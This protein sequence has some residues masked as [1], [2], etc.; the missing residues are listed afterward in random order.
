MDLCENLKTNDSN[1]F[2]AFAKWVRD[3]YR[4]AEHCLNVSFFARVAETSLTEWHEVAALAWARSNNDL[5]YPFVSRPAFYLRCTQLGLFS[6]SVNAESI[7]GTG[8]GQD[9]YFR[10]CNDIFGADFDYMLLADSVKRLNFQFGGKVP[11]VNGIIFTNGKLD[12][13]FAFGITEHVVEGNQDVLVRNLAGNFCFNVMIFRIDK[14][15]AL[16]FRLWKVGRFGFDKR[17]R[18][19]RVDRS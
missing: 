17:I 10:G 14:K 12:A 6:T 13:H 18:Y 1:E 9:L 19:A 8:I 3:T 2:R 15:I 16:V 4:T 11:N 7:F 5:S